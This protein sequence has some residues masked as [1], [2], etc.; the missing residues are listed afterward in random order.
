[1]LTPLLYA[2]GAVVLVLALTYGKALLRVMSVRL[3]R[4]PQILRVDPAD[5]PLDVLHALKQGAAELG[6]VGF[7]LQG[8]VEEDHSIAGVDEPSWSAVYGRADG[9]A[10]A[11]VSLA[12]APT[13]VQR[14][15]LAFVSFA[16]NGAAIETVAYHAHRML[17]PAPEHRLVD[18]K[19]LSWRE[20][21]ACHERT[22][23]GDRATA[24]RLDLD[25]FVA[26]LAALRRS[27]LEHGCRKGDYAPRDA[28][29]LRFRLR[30][31][32]AIIVRSTNGE[33]ARLKA[34]PPQSA[35][36]AAPDATGTTPEL[37]AH[38]RREAVE[39]SRRTGGLTK[40]AFF[41]ASVALFAFAFGISL[42]VD[43]VLLLFGVLLFHE[44]GHALAM[45][46]FGYQDL[47]I[48][49][50]PFL[51]A[52][53]AGRKRDTR[54][55]EE[56]LVL[57]AGPV[58][59][60]AV[61]T[62]LLLS[63]RAESGTWLANAAY[64]MLFLN[65]M[66]LLPIVP[67]DGGRILN[68]ILFDRFPRLQI[69]FSSL[70]GAALLAGGYALGDTVLKVVGVALLVG[71]PAQLSHAR[72]LASVQ[73]A[74]RERRQRAERGRSDE[75]DAADPLAMIY[76][77]LQ[78][79]KFDRWNVE[80]KYQVATSLLERARRRPAGLGVAAAG[81]AAWF[82]GMTVPLGLIAYDQAAKLMVSVEEVEKE[83]RL[84]VAAW[85][86]KI[87]AA[88]SDAARATVLR[89]AGAASL[90]DG[91]W[92]DAERYLVRAEPLAEGRDPALEASIH[93][94][95][96]QTSQASSE[97]VSEDEA[98]ALSVSAERHLDRA[99]ALREETFGRESLEVAEVLAAYPAYDD[100]ANPA[101]ALARSER[102]VAIYETA[103]A[104]DPSRAGELIYALET[105]GTLHALAKDDAAAERR[106]VQAA[107]VARSSD[108]ALRST[109]LAGSLATLC[110]F[111]FAR[112]RYADVVPLLD[113]REALISGD[114]VM[115]TIARDAVLADRAWL[116]YWQGEYGTARLRF[117][118]LGG[119]SLPAGLAMLQSD[120]VKVPIWLDE[121]AAAV[122]V[123]DRARA[124][125]LLE[126]AG[127]V[128]QDATGRT[129]REYA[130]TLDPID[131]GPWPRGEQ[132][133]RGAERAR[134]LA[135]LIERS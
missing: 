3:R 53:A 13:R 86:A 42:S 126:R 124:A 51:G 54:P 5:V 72:I 31:A 112:E 62:A 14:L 45:R 110:E 21:W 17:P 127:E 71:V 129:L 75:L 34:L 52:V 120:L 29:S 97:E 104:A 73:G 15:E 55:H 80:T 70:S 27:T 36:A 41:A 20:Q 7:A 113:E 135:P 91:Y 2:A 64:M 131:M 107:A 67:L 88:P 44:L 116:A 128:I 63:G 65:Y 121:A 59:G 111:Y 43:T 35:P 99:L 103:A 93:L 19:T 18:A 6:E 81:M 37:A 109:A 96:A 4:A 94:L 95:L 28:G 134:V 133:R 77:E 92:D 76:T 106:L 40:L 90:E 122:R 84:S 60:I 56:I 108:P 12:E 32:L 8:V 85:D 69:L 47:Q 58:P 1:V 78:Q 49:F 98:A 119:R 87:E 68:I 83:R 82:L 11:V 48:L 61:G 74:L 9:R 57:L 125:S 22:L 39:R 132:Q 16:P 66:N 102:L 10:F 46:A 38:R 117:A 50:I 24:A 30:A 115:A 123:G 100:P 23:G 25:A 26:R 118:E 33:G 130:D 105:A 79:P 89:D 114:D 101:A